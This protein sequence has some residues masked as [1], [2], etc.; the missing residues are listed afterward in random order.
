L[1]ATKYRRPIYTAL[2]N[3]PFPDA[4]IRASIQAKTQGENE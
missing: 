1:H 3:F 4:A 2:A